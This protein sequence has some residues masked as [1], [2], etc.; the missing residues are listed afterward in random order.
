VRGEDARRVSGTAEYPGERNAAG[1]LPT[2]G[3]FTA[4]APFDNPQVTVTVFVEKGGGPSD[5]L[6]LAM[7]LLKEYFRRY[8]TGITPAATPR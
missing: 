6:P 1:I 8:P 5:A 7:E 3:G 2:H 4:Y